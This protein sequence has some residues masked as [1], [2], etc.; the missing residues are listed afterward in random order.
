MK[1]VF[2]LLVTFFLLFSAFAASAV[3]VSAADGDEGIGVPDDAF[4]GGYTE[5]KGSDGSVTRVFDNG[6]V[7]TK[8]KDGSVHAVDY[9]GNTY[10][11]NTDGSSTIRTTDGFVATEYN[12]G[13]K[14]LTEPNGKTTTVNSDGSFSESYG[15]GLTL[16]YDADGGLTGV[17]ITGSDERIGTDENGYYKNGVIIGPN[18]S[19][20]TVTDE[21]MRFVNKD[22][23]VYDH[24]DLGNKQTT[25]IE[26]KDGS[27]CTSE[28]TVSWNGNEKT[29]NTDFSLTDANGE[30]WNANVQTSFDENGEPKY[31][32]NNVV[33]WTS[34]DGSSL[35]MDNNS[36]AMNFRGKDGTVMVVDSSG[37][38]TEYKDSNTV[39]NVKYDENGNVESADITFSDGAKMIKNADGTASF[40]LPDGTKYESDSDGNVFKNGEQIKKD[41]Q[42]LPGKEESEK[43]PDE[44]GQSEQ[45]SQSEQSG[46]SELAGWNGT[47]NGTA[48]PKPETKGTITEW[49][50]KRDSVTIRID[51]MSYQ[52]YIDYCRKLEAL[53]GW[54][55]Y[56]G[57]DTAHLPNDYNERAKVYFTGEYSNLPHISVQYYS[58]KTCQ[59]NKLPHFC[60]FVFYEW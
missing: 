13:R 37:N 25:S 48:L 22:G 2:A 10:S 41:G 33:Q 39:W 34:S 54:T 59:H 50:V 12:D 14:S 7:S 60:M 16:D 8:N 57:E 26:W 21:G 31:I 47:F 1:K 44:S 19:M 49:T 20:L 28:T 55:V 45:S 35:W 52:E 40:T 38:L 24:T 53:P 9:K 46:Q 56:G 17:G 6:S 5:Y 32:K 58:D 51:G 23:T 11:E 42:W 27:H 29:E 43:A 36:E 15:V 3:C 4:D 30:Q 18:G